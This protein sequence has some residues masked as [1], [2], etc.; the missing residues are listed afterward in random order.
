VLEVFLEGLRNNKLATPALLE[1]IEKE[2]AAIRKERD[3]I[4]I[5]LAKAG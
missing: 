5:L 4:T 1:S 2:L 3:R